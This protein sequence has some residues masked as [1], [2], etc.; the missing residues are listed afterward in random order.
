LAQVTKST[1]VNGDPSG[2]DILFKPEEFS[3]ILLSPRPEI[4]RRGYGMPPPEKAYLAFLMLYNGDSFYNRLLVDTPEA[5]ILDL[6]DMEEDSAI[7]WLAGLRDLFAGIDPFK[8]PVLYNHDIP[9]KWIPFTRPPSEISYNE[10]T[11]KYAKVLIGSYW[12]RVSD[13]GI[14]Q[15]TN[16]LAGQ[17]RDERSMRLTGFGIVREKTR[18][19]INRDILPPYLKFVWIE[20]DEEALIQRARARLLMGQAV[21][22]LI[23][24][25]TLKPEDAQKMLMAD[26]LIPEEAELPPP[27]PPEGNE[28]NPSPQITSEKNNAE[29]TPEKVADRQIENEVRKKEATQGGVGE[30]TGRIERSYTTLI[31]H[32]TLNPDK[33]SVPILN[34]KQHPNL[35]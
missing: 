3:R 33:I 27:P 7:E 26:G 11:M 25:Q 18:N 15:D 32:E 21:K 28:P 5:G 13:V 17:I 4:T 12:L 6:M 35:E 2:Y 8:I 30:S 34:G 16:S 10:I 31:P 14:G 20:N 1:V 23:E 24:A 19:M 29:K 22:T 9:A